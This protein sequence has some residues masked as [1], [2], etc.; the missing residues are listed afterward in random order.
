VTRDE[1]ATFLYYFGAR[2]QSRAEQVELI[3]QVLD[4]L[5]N[6]E[7]AQEARFDL[8]IA[9]AW[10]AFEQLWPDRRHRWRAEHAR[11]RR[12]VREAAGLAPTCPE[13]TDYHLAQWFIL[14]QE[15]CID[16]VLDRVADYDSD[17]PWD[18]RAAS[19]LQR[20]AEESIPFRKALQ[21]AREAR[22]LAMLVQ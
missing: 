21:K 11:L 7:W 13:W 17:L 5:E 9:G 19:K 18:D 2:K 1:Y 4:T 22:M 8:P 12:R 16:A 10:M 20:L 6:A 15:K 3:P 14:R